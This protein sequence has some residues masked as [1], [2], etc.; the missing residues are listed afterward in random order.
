MF[1][2]LT[3]LSSSFR[4]FPRVSGDVST[5]GAIPVGSTAFSP[6]ERG[7]F[8][9]VRR[10]GMPPVISPRGRG[11]FSSMLMKDMTP[12]FSPRKWGGL[13]Y[14]VDFFFLKVFT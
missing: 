3:A 14:C 12:F 13:S 8:T 2:R 4:C 11:C 1:L 5:A 6:R 7:C 9:S 10:F